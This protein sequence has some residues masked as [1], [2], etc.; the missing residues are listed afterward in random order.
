[1]GKLFSN[2][3]FEFSKIFQKNYYFSL[4]SKHV[5]CCFCMCSFFS[6]FSFEIY[7]T[8]LT[9]HCH[10]CLFT[11]I[12]T[13]IKLEL[14][15]LLNTFFSPIKAFKTPTDYRLSRYCDSSVESL[16]LSA[17]RCSKSL[18]E[19]TEANDWFSLN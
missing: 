6:H 19:I 10:K 18:C 5:R 16:R 2:L 14:A 12:I 17:L 3:S 1:M 9:M 7:S 8:Y 15:W 4:R 13:Q 11:W